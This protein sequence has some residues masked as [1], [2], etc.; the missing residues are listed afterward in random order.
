M[1]VFIAGCFVESSI[2]EN[3]VIVK[4]MSQVTS[5]LSVTYFGAKISK[6]RSRTAILHEFDISDLDVTFD[7]MLANVEVS[8]SPQLVWITRQS[9]PT[10]RVSIH[11]VRFGRLYVEEFEAGL[12]VFHVLDSC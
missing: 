11:F 6:T 3:T 5:L 9:F 7:L 1:F 8:Y 2:G 12:Y 10:G 4:P